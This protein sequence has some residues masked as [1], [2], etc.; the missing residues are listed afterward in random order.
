MRDMTRFDAQ[1]LFA[2]IDNHRRFTGSRQ[3]TRIVERWSDY[4][5]KFVKVMPVDYRR[6]LEQMQAR[7]RATERTGVSMAVGV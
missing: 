4:L 6:A 2:L 7:W 3:A 1:R 5:P